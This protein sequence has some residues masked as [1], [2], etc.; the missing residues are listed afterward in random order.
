MLGWTI[1]IGIGIG[2]EIIMTSEH[3][4]VRGICKAIR[5]G[6]VKSNCVQKEAEPYEQVESDPDSDP[7][8]DRIKT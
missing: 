2:I 6:I 7:D 5:T 4:K 1:Q 8:F 3:D